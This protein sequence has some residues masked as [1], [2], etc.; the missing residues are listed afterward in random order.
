MLLMLL[1]RRLLLWL[2]LLLLMLHSFPASG[3]AVDEAGFVR[4]YSSVTWHRTHRPRSAKLRLLDVGNII[5]W[6][7]QESTSGH[8]FK[9]NATELSQKLGRAYQ[10]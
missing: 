2:L 3:V 9:A 7:W 6:L 10:L 8:R 1:R 4:L 5:T